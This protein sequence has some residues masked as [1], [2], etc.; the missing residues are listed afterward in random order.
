MFAAAASA[1]DVLGTDGGGP[2]GAS[3]AAVAAEEGTGA[4]EARAKKEKKEKK[5]KKKRKKEKSSSQKRLIRDLKVLMSDEKPDGINAAPIDNNIFKWQA[6]IFGP[7]DSPWEGGTFNLIL[8]F[9]E[10]Y[11]NKPPAV[12]FVSAIFHP[13]VYKDGRICVDILKESMWTPIFETSHILISIQSLLC[14]PN[15]SSPAN[16]EAA[17]LWRENRREYNRRVRETVSA[18]NSSWTAT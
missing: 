4:S 8:D 1:E 14:D 7:A 9:P 2:S 5:K 13:N 12:R 18:S 11:P 6:V 3:G 16:V 17:T 10:D 15:P